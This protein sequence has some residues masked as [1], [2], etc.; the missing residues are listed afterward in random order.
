MTK[1]VNWDD[2]TPEQQKKLLAQAE[3]KAK[4]EKEEKKA[5]RKTFKKLAEEFV[6]DNISNLIG[7]QNAT[8]VIIKKLFEDHKNLL[9]LKTMA[10]GNKVEE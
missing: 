4:Q 5:N 2:L 7:H 10:Y 6:L 8:E 3:Q 9:E 1:Q